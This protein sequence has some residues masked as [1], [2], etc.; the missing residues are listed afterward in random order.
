MNWWKSGRKRGEGSYRD[1]RKDGTW[2]EWDDN[3]ILRVAQDYRDGVLH[4]RRTVW[5][6][7][8]NRWREFSYVGGQLEGEFS[9]WHENGELKATGL[10]RD[11]HKDGRWLAWDG[12]GR[13]S[14][15]F[16]ERGERVCLASQS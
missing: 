16:Y 13:L 1:G 12:E 14:E 10:Y 2:F 5:N 8:G 9:E 15:E 6:S 3:G 4:G 7:D 11:G